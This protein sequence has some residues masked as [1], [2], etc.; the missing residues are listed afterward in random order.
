M[1]EWTEMNEW[2]NEWTNERTN[3]RMSESKT[4]ME[5]MN[6]W[7]SERMNECKWVERAINRL[8]HTD[9]ELSTPVVKDK[10]KSK[11]Q[12]KFKFEKTNILNIHNNLTLNM[13][14]WDT[15]AVEFIY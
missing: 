11:T 2:M 3:E 4:K 5:W 1:K 10:N 15:A 14:K 7:T 8:L 9:T 12:T 6:E 13:T